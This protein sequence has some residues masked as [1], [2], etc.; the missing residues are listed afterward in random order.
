M[1]DLTIAEPYLE[2]CPTYTSAVSSG[3]TPR[4]LRF[5]FGQHGRTLPER[6]RER[7]QHVVHDNLADI[8]KLEPN[9]RPS[10][11]LPLPPPVL[12]DSVYCLGCTGSCKGGAGGRYHDEALHVQAVRIL[13]LRS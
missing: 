11:H 3:L 9:N 13:R 1:L 12:T 2:A 8:P 6:T 4:S 10:L 5:P 7:E